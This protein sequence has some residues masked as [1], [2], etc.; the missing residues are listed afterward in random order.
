MT[1]YTRTLEK[2]IEQTLLPADFSPT[3]LLKSGQIPFLLIPRISKDYP[4]LNLANE[5]IVLAHIDVEQARNY[6]FVLTQKRFY[7]QTEDLREQIILLENIYTNLV[8]NQQLKLPLRKLSDDTKARLV[9]LFEKISDQKFDLE[10]NRLD[11]LVKKAEGL[12]EKINEKQ[13]PIDQAL[14]D[15]L[16]NEGDQALQLCNSLAQNETFRQNL[17]NM[18]QKSTPQAHEYQAWHVLMQDFIN[19]YKAFEALKPETPHLKEQFALAYM[20]EKLQNADMATSIS[21]P[22]INQMVTNPSFQEKIGVVKNANFFTVADTYKNQP[23]L[24]M[25]LKRMGH[26]AH[27]Q[28]AALVYR[29][30]QL[31]AKANGEIDSDEEK[32]LAQ[33]WQTAYQPAVNLP[34][35]KQLQA[36]TNETLDDVMKELNELI[37]LQDIKHEIQSLINLLKVSQMRKEQG[38]QAAMPSLHSVFVGPPGTGKTTI[39]RMLGR[40]FKQL[41]IL[42]KGHCVETDRAGLVAG[43]IGQ[44][45][46]KTDEVVQSALDGVLFIDEAYALNRGDDS[47]KDFGN[48]AI[49]TL[50]KR[51]EDYR[52]RLVVVVAGYPTEMEKFIHSNPGLKSRFNRY[53][54]FNHYTAG[55][56]LEIFKL[57]ARKADFQLST[58]AEEKLSFIFEALCDKPHFSFGNARTA[59]NLFEECVQHQANRLVNVAPITKE[60]LITLE[61][62]DIPEVNETVKKIKVFDEGAA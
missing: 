57:F 35:V 29:F 47:G 7:Y 28:A 58:D 2:L 19:I 46:L 39:A 45:A 30:A 10:K 48:E 17:Q 1:H 44:T 50:L 5:E 8:E 16:Q 22:R 34:N 14:I 62:P 24:P 53:F 56:L 11:D 12:Q 15:I 41:G 31:I 20:F 4:S 55:E 43:F 33:I 37:G 42:Q 32:L 59:R 54:W 52:D 25:L 23:L 3:L 18:L 38:L 61:E 40:I 27:E 26:P 9:V 13:G 6:G 36:P 21:L 51:M 49:E 60:Q